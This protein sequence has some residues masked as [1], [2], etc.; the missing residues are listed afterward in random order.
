MNTE[1]SHRLHDGRMLAY[2]EY[3]KHQGA[4]VLFCHG[5]PGSRL[6]ITP[7]M[8]TTAATLGMRLIVPDRPGYGLSDPWPDRSLV[9]W[10]HDV[11]ALMDAL[12]ISEFGVVGFSVGGIHALA[13]A[14]SLPNRVTGVA[15]AGAFAQNL[16]EP[17]V[18]ATLSPAVA[19]AL[20]QARDDPDGLLQALAPLAQ[21]PEQLFA[22]MVDTVSLP[23]QQVLK[24]QDVSEAIRS[25]CREGLHQG[26]AAIL[27]DY[28]F[29]V[30][31][32]GIALEGIVVP[33]D[34]WQGLADINAPPAMSE[35]LAK[36]LPHC[37]VHHLPGEGH[38]CLFTHWA[39]VLTRL[40]G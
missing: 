5:T 36:Q 4:P 16:L 26:V 25:D 37:R 34:I 15:L 14:R 13:C 27:Q 28:R 23:D 18:A 8:A 38:L 17:E 22:M 7:E 20:S 6:G 21:A 29:A 39:D 12:G 19:Q 33:V 32:W 11:A 9:D 3:G 10:P 24:Q 31:G 1:Q 30:G 35:Y 40:R 2:A